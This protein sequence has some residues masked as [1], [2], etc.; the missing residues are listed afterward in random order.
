MFFASI[1]IIRH[2]HRTCMLGTWYLLGSIVTLPLDRQE[3]PL[4]KEIPGAP[5]DSKIN[6]IIRTP[7]LIIHNFPSCDSNRRPP[8]YES[9]ALQSCYCAAL[10]WSDSDYKNFMQQ[11]LMEN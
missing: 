8:D 2:V 3:N 10:L 7:T 6:N 4:E 5:I 9:N 1:I 11:R